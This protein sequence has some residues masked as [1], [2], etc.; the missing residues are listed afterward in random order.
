MS[1]LIVDYGLCNL[2]SI[3][4]AVEICGA[5]SFISSDP[6]DIKTAERIILP[7]VGAFGDAMKN[8][9]S[10]GWDKA[11]EEEVIGLGIPLL[12]ICLGMQLL[13]DSSEE[14]PGIE[15]LGLIPGKVKLLQP[16]NPEERIPH[17]G[18]N[19]IYTTCD[20]PLLQGIN[21][22]TDFYFVHS[23]HFET[24]SKENVAATTP[25]CTEFTSVVQKNNVY[26][27]QFH[28]EKSVPAGFKILKNFL[29]V[30]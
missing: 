19:E 21:E 14:S 3:R 15:G 17:I 26:G 16:T 27:T 9:R 8:I 29:E 18:W 5:N 13:A 30:C 28:P 25:Y 10:T 11:I 20:S 4:R 22:G 7:G 6:K 24:E 23:Y 1:V 12:G 2:N